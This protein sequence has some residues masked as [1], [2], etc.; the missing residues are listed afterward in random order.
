[1]D[2]QP[3]EHFLQSK[4]FRGIMY[5]LGI[6]FA[7]ALIF[8]AGVA[9]G[10]HRAFFAC[11]WGENYGR[12]FGDRANVFIERAPA[13]FEKKITGFHGVLGK[14]VVTTDYGVVVLGKDGVERGVIV[15][16][17][18]EIR[19]GRDERDKDGLKEGLDV[20]IFGEPNDEGRILA[21]LIRILT[22]QLQP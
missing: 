14:V 9:M 19:S 15:D 3:K 21:K 2:I 17:H 20:M 6:A 4:T 18:T 7:V 10:S 12:S 16:D 8:N 1:M 5:G 11:K 13:P 22:E